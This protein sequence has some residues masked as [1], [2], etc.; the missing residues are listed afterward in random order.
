MYDSIEIE[1]LLGISSVRL[2][3]LGAIN[4]IVG[5]HGSGKTSVLDAIELLAEGGT[6]TAFGRMLGRRSGAPAGC[7]R[8]WIGWLTRNRQRTGAIRITAER[9][10]AGAREDAAALTVTPEPDT[11]TPAG[12]TADTR[13]VWTTETPCRNAETFLSHQDGW[14]DDRSVIA[15]I[16]TDG[17][18][19]T[20]LETGNERPERVAQWHATDTERQA[21]GRAAVERAL[22]A[23]GVRCAAVRLEAARQGRAE[24]VMIYQ[25]GCRHAVPIDTFGTGATRFTTITTATRRPGSRYLLIEGVDQGIQPRALEALW[26]LIAETMASSNT[27]Q[28]FATADRIETIAALGTVAA[29]LG[30]PATL[31]RIE[32]GRKAVRLSREAMAALNERDVEVR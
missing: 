25:P 13:H 5:G 22:A 6:A 14:C 24:R 9:A 7:D 27:R 23:S 12:G 21:G 11:E 15:G 32:R 3:E 8:V 2:T 31:H 1:N 29:R 26:T 18:R 20:R 10:D 4:L 17:T 28:V 19:T 16:G 30:T